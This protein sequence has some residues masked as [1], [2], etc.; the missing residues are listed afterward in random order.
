MFSNKE[1]IKKLQ[2][3]GPQII[4]GWTTMFKYESKNGKGHHF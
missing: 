1:L 3:I 2:I 4:V